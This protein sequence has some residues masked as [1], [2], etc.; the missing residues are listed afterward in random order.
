[1]SIVVIMQCTLTGLILKLWRKCSNPNPSGT[2]FVRVRSDFKFQPILR[3]T[4]FYWNI[5]RLLHPPL[6]TTLPSLSLS[7]PS[8]LSI[9]AHNPPPLAL[10]N[11]ATTFSTL[12]LTTSSVI[13]S[14]RLPFPF[15]QHA[16][17]CARR[18]PREGLVFISPLFACSLPS[19][20]LFVLL[21]PAFRLLLFSPDFVVSHPSFALS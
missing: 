5:L 14:F 17:R 19:P 16:S 13:L 7:T 2:C 1:M 21:V 18:F 8:H 4:T 12:L 9:L 11:P 6:N 15:S 20:A 10:K 3:V